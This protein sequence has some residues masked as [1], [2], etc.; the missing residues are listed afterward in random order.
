AP[1]RAYRDAGTHRDSDGTLDAGDFPAGL[2]A[3]LDAN[4]FALASGMPRRTTASIPDVGAAFAVQS[5]VDEIAVVTKQDAVALRLDLLGE[6]RQI[7]YAGRGG[8]TFDTG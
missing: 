7:A 3:N 1:P 8:P 5:F 4:F 2:V 6:P